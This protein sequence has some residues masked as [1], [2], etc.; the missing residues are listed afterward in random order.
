MVE[1]NANIEKDNDDCFNK[2][3]KVLLILDKL[4]YN[5]NNTKTSIHIFKPF[6]YILH[7]FRN[8]RNCSL[9]LLIF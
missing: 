3:F 1:L 9:T 4:E 7:G 6:I 2:K 5:L 8:F